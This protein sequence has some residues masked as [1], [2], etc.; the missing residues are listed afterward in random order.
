MDGYLKI[1]PM[2]ISGKENQAMQENVF[3]GRERELEEL[4]VYLRRALSGKGQV[5]FVTGQAG[6]GKT[7]L[8]R[9]FMQ[10]ALAADPKLVETLGSCNAQTGIGDPYLPFREALTML[11]GDAAA[12]ESAGKIAPQNA[13]RLRAVLVRSVQVLVEAAPE[14]IGLFVPGV[15]LLGAVGKAVVEKVGWMDRLD[16]LARRKVGA[17]E[18]VAEQS[19]IF[20]QYTAFVQRLSTKTPLVVFLD[21]LQWADNASLGLL[22][23]LARRI[24]TSRILVLGAYR[25]DD[26]ALGR[27]GER[28]PLEPVVH[29][30]TR[31]KG[32]VTVD[33]DAIPETV[34]RVFVDTLLDAEPN[35]LGPSFRQVLFHRTG[36]H[37]LFTVELVRTLQERGD[38]VRDADGRWVEGPSLD[39]D[40]LPARVEGVIAER[41][42]RLGKELQQMLTVGSVEGEQFAA[43]V[44]AR[45]QA[46]SKREVIRGLSNCLQRQ[47]RLVSALGVI[48]FGFVGLSLYAFVHHLFQQYV[49]ASL[50]E[51][52]RTHLHRDVGEA[53]EDLLEGRTEEVAAQLARHFEEA[54]IPGKAAAYRLQAGNRAHRL[55]AHQEAAAHLTR[56]LKLLASLPPGPKRMEL[57]LDLQTSLGTTLIA[58]QGY[59]SPEVKRAYARARELCRALGDPPQVIPVLFGLCL[60]YM[61]HGE[62]GKARD[63][64]ER[65]LQL[66]QHAGDVGYVMGVHFP[67]GQTFLM[68]ADFERSRWHLEQVLA[69]YDPSRDRDLAR[70]QVHDPA[71]ASLLFLSWTLWLQGYPEQATTKME[72]ALELAEELNQPYTNTQAALLASCFYQF[73]RHWPQCQR[74]SE[75]ALELSHQGHFRFLQAGCTMHRG[76]ALAHQGR[77]EEGI[78]VLRQGLDAWEATG[79]QLALPY[80]HARLAEAYLLAGRRGE[81]LQA[82]DKSFCSVEEVWWLAEQYR[83][84]AELLL[85][86]P[87]FET[88]AEALLRQALALARDQKSKSLELRAAMSQ[89]RLLHRQGRAAEGRDL[90]AERYAWFSEGFDTADLQEAKELL[91]VLQR[92]AE[93]ASPTR[94]DQNRGASEAFLVRPARASHDA[95]PVAA[96]PEQMAAAE[97]RFI[98]QSTM[99]WE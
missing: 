15:T 32:D 94:D 60:F 90:L 65:L 52:E 49:Y 4:N 25:P 54:G 53:L 55:S 20:E 63:E 44:V 2:A 56:G 47:H 81:G 70:Q 79:T 76:S 93:Q 14:L 19:R 95:S 18:P 13:E 51:A 92:D 28:H 17:S 26:V 10:Q 86:A 23:H 66:A 99:R 68:Q 11:T 40:A 42:A 75:R 46:M 41:I 9:Q 67:L 21:D 22:F 58:T 29:E 3:V 84:R 98:S 7:A 48:Q 50:G 96:G 74:H 91:A 16:E 6:S 35:R 1:P 87:G 33:L 82:I 72:A 38:L 45:V 39:W 73:L 12:Q 85:L 62:L 69:L 64:G 59:A 37:A 31:Y 78:A 61:M 5:C 88:E 80:S 30:L 8:V 57:E 24:E 97:L 71:V 43:E 83:V 89:A 36:G 34:N 77:V 27:G